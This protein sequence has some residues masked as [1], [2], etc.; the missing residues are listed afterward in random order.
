MKRVTIVVILCVA[1]SGCSRQAAD[2]PEN[3]RALAQRF[4]REVTP[5]KPMLEAAASQQLS[6][7]PVPGFTAEVLAELQFD[8]VEAATVDCMTK[9]FTLAELETLTDFYTSPV[10]QSYREKFP[11]YSAE[12]S[13]L[14]KQEVFRAAEVVKERGKRTQQSP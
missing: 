1:A 13:S 6:A 9:H 8:K 10:A 3:R 14:M 2:T 5:L 7:S 11:A 12:V 4:A